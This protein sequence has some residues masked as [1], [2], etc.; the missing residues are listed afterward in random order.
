M[1][2]GN[3]DPAPPAVRPAVRNL[4]NSR[5]TGGKVPFVKHTFEWGAVIAAFLSVL[6]LVARHCPRLTDFLHP[7]SRTINAP[8]L[9]PLLIALPLRSPWAG[10]MLMIMGSRSGQCC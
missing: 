4:R 9:P 8:L 7:K 3:A 2:R 5:G 1:P 6:S 10:A